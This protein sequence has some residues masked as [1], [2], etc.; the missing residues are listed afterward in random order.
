MYGKG[1]E[2]ATDSREDQKIT[3]LSLHLLQLC[4]GYINT[5]MMQRVLNEPQ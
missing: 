1:G 5:L 3:M 2:F 4:L